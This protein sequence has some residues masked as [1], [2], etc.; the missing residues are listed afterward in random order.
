M[1]SMER[2]SLKKKYKSNGFAAGCSREGLNEKVNST[3]KLNSI[4]ETKF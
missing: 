1:G 3:V 2:K 4:V